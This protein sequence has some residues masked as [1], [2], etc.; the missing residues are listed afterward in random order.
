LK[1][2]FKSRLTKE[3]YINGV[4]SGDRVI[5]SQAIT[6]TESRLEED[7]HI[8]SEIIAGILPR[9]GRS[10]R[11]GITGVPG[12]GKSTFIEAFGALLSNLGKKIAVLAIDP[13][14]KRTG[15]SILGDKTRMEELSR[16]PNAYIRPSP[17]G[18]SLGGVAAKTRESILLCEAAGFEVILVETVGVG[19][20]ETEVRNMVD[21]FLLLMLPGAGDELQGIKK[22]IMEMADAIVI[23][24]ADGDNLKKANEAKENYNQALHLF[25]ANPSGW[26]TPVLTCSALENN[27]LDV[28]W[29]LIEEFREFTFANNYFNQNRSKQNI[30]W[31]HNHLQSLIQA[32][33][34]YNE[35]LKDQISAEELRVANG[36]VSAAVAAKKIFD[37]WIGSI[38]K[39]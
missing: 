28:L 32:S 22:G 34:R 24:K 20:S 26:N 10:I 9:S 27:G 1:S 37:Q 31:M 39:S 30:V 2:R 5:L 15:G 7:Q 36:E 17:T 29:K 35:S 6:L 8:S 12:V 23:N 33:I 14:S 18:Q 25:E 11:I 3:A 16:N 4:L 21:F 13:S 38:K 19:Q